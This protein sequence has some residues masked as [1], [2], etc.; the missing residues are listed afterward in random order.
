MARPSSMDAVSSNSNSK[1]SKKSRA[2]QRW[3]YEP[4]PTLP[5]TSIANTELD[6]FLKRKRTSR[7]ISGEDGGHE[8]VREERGEKE[9]ED[10][11]SKRRSTRHSCGVFST[12]DLAKLAVT[13]VHGTRKALQRR[14]T[15]SA[16]ID[17]NDGDWE[18]DFD[19]SRAVSGSTLVGDEEA[20]LWR[21]SKREGDE[22]SE[23]SLV[24]VTSSSGK[25]QNDRRSS[26]LSLFTKAVE[27]AATVLGKR[28]REVLGTG[29]KT[30][31]SLAAEAKAV[32]RNR[33]HSLRD[34]QGTGAGHEEKTDD[35]EELPKRKKS[36]QSVEN[37][38]G[39]LVSSSEG[40]ISARKP[41]TKVK[42]W[43]QSGL[44]AGQDQATDSASGLKRHRRKST[45]NPRIAKGVNAT[46][47]LPVFAGGR[48]L[49]TGRDFKLPFDLFCPL[50]PGQPKPE[51]WRK[52]QTNRFIG[53]AIG[54]WKR[55]KPLPPSKCVCT[56]SRGC[57]EHC[58][59]RFMLYECDDSNCAIGRPL[60]TN[61]AFGDLKERLK[62]GNR[63]DVGV[64][65]TKTVD[66]GYGVRSARTF[67]PGQIIVE[68]AGEIITQEECERRMRNEYKSNDVSGWPLK[69]GSTLC[70]NRH[71][72][73]VAAVLLPNDL[74]PKHDHRCHKG[75]HSTLREPLLRAKLPYGEMDRFRQTA[76]GAFRR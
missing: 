12:Y 66:R 28:T 55:V 16:A 45:A 69:R 74:R 48:L 62:K 47:P 39:L 75:Q 65:V 64:E 58:F 3:H 42:K 61:R 71:E 21:G 26:R 22:F 67:E 68:Y 15:K 23:E 53:D 72:T 6:V 7:S 9:E 73:D 46:L 32:E 31:Q 43:L 36:R 18:H 19:G 8:E 1:S 56:P 37:P 13:E 52:T 57:D 35:E 50:P 38:P 17:G 10:V 44:Y 25:L 59:N 14:M 4:E 20:N 30:L 41:P 63:Y 2:S 11:Q 27:K 49:Q 24:G 5:I 33:N 70:S 51:E 60:C 29:K 34:R 54:E 40:H 76:H